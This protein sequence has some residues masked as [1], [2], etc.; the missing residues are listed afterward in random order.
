MPT[1]RF[2]VQRTGI[3]TYKK[4]PFGLFPSV[5]S[6]F[7]TNHADYIAMHWE[8]RKDNFQKAYTLTCKNS[9]LHLISA[10]S[11]AF[12]SICDNCEW[13]FACE[14]L[15]IITYSCSSFI[16]F[17]FIASSLLFDCGFYS[18]GLSFRRLYCAHE[19]I[20]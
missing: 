5:A 11:K 18:Q 16:L 8:R 2:H 20:E 1:A 4:N 6:L 12:H 15:F 7:P 14:S 9:T 19:E 17:S 10:H 3:Q 13:A